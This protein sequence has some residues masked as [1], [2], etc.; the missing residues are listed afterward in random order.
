MCPSWLN[1]IGARSRRQKA[2]ASLQGRRREHAPERRIGS[3]RQKASA[4]LQ[5]SDMQQG[6]GEDSHVPD[7]KRRLPH[8]R[9][10]FV[11][12]YERRPAGSRRQK[13]SASLQDIRLVA[14]V[15]GC[16]VPDA[17]R[18]LP[19]CRLLHFPSHSRRGVVP[20]AKRRLPHCRELRTNAPHDE[21]KFQTPKGVCLIAVH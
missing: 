10:Y 14:G 18:R 19:H 3:R 6:A 15:R 4:S 9:S 7:A 21:R 2:S 17:K 11:A 8:C 12:G 13:A 20:D 1:S 5:A 16:Q